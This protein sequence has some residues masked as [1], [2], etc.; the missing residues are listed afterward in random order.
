M[1]GVGRML[2]DIRMIRTSHRIGYLLDI[3]QMILM[4]GIMIQ[5]VMLGRN[6]I[7]SRPEGEGFKPEPGMSSGYL[8]ISGLVSY[9]PC[10]LF[11]SFWYVE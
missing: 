1:R 6:Q 11:L 3:I 2:V 8:Y 10:S 5:L 4:P 9:R 7:G